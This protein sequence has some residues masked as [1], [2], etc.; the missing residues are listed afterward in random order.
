[1]CVWWAAQEQL[2]EAV[3]ASGMNLADPEYQYPADY[4][5][6]SCYDGDQPGDWAPYDEPE[7]PAEADAKRRRLAV[8]YD[9][10]KTDAQYYSY[11]T[12]APPPPAPAPAP[13]PAGGPTGAMTREEAE[14][15]AARERV[16][17]ERRQAAAT[18]GRLAAILNMV[19]SKHT[20]HTFR[21]F[22]PR[23]QIS[24]QISM[25][26]SRHPKP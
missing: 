22:I 10:P 4:A 9:Y 25:Q 23:V 8:S 1:M 26:I 7:D 15:A 14:R 11:L 24:M 16:E 6:V 13:A 12:P 17:E 2:V 19:P 18:Q 21:H 5:A 20:L 3:E